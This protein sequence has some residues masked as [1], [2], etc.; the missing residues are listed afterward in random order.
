M[1]YII[2]LDP[3]LENEEPL[4]FWSSLLDQGW[5]RYLQGTVTM[6]VRNLADVDPIEIEEIFK[7]N[8]GL[9]EYEKALCIQSLLRTKLSKAFHQFIK[10]I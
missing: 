8:N 1:A 7:S 2:K 6:H 4:D 9:E 3:V 10:R 5:K